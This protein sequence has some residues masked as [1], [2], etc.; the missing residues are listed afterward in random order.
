MTISKP[1]DN[2]PIIIIPSTCLILHKQHTCP[3]THE[4][5]HAYLRYYYST[6]HL[7]NDEAVKT[8]EKDPL[9]PCRTRRKRILRC[10]YVLCMYTFEPPSKSGERKTIVSAP[11][12]CSI[13]LF[14]PFFFFP[15]ENKTKITRF[16]LTVASKDLRDIC[17]SF[18]IRSPFVRINLVSRSLPL[19]REE[20][21]GEGD[22]PGIAEPSCYV[23]SNSTERV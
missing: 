16:S 17:I 11:E 6:F 21:G 15:R 10:V 12:Y 13:F 23:N 18:G 4:R 2:S 1:F 8:L 3:N 22:C 19:E 20:E 14:F 9:L 7:D 5:E